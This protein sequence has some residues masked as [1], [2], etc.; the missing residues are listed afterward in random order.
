MLSRSASEA[1]YANVEVS[2][3][4]L[5]AGPDA[6]MLK[7]WKAQAAPG[8]PRLAVRYPRSSGREAVVWAGRLDAATAKGLLDSPARREIARRILKRDSVVW[9]LLESGNRQKDDAAAGLLRA[10]LRGLE[11]TLELPELVPDDFGVE[12]EDMPELRLAFSMV[13]LSRTDPAEEMLVSMLLKSE[14]D[15]EKF[16]EPMAFPVFGR[17]RVLY[18]LVGKGINEENI[19]GACGFLVGPCSCIVKAENPGTDLLMSVDWEN[20]LSGKLAIDEALPPLTGFSG[21]VEGDGTGTV[22]PPAAGR[23][24]EASARA[25]PGALTR[26]VLL[27]VGIG[28]A[29]VLAASLVIVRRRGGQQP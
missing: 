18:A 24:A 9:V 6:S 7:L 26:N 22:E 27:L 14:P 12:P 13:R 3:V 17:G 28:A 20:L 21:F 15:L 11:E 5:A 1:P 4:D 19:A 29:G 10:Q 2:T 16:S 25:G 23:V 8:Q